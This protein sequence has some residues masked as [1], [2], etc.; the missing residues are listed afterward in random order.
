MKCFC[1]KCRARRR[2]DAQRYFATGELPSYPS[3]E[4]GP[5]ERYGELIGK[6]VGT[7]SGKGPFGSYI[8]GKFFG[9]LGWT[10]DQIFWDP[11]PPTRP[12]AAPPTPPKKIPEPK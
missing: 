3:R 11:K 6:G 5:G 10:V 2:R 7:V 12:G 4:R 1:D 9:F 8:Y